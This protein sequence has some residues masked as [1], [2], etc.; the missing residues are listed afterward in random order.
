[1]TYVEKI[2]LLLP[3]SDADILPEFVEDCLHD[4]VGLIAIS[5]KDSSKFDDWIDELVVGDGSDPS[6]FIVTSFHEDESMENVVDFV[7][8]WSKKGWRE[9]RNAPFQIVEL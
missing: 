7:R 3:I 5:G 9:D 2:I 4:G 6:R 8:S 1:M